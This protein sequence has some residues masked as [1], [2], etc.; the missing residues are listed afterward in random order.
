MLR[1]VLMAYDG[2]GVAAMACR[3]E[4]V[5]VAQTPSTRLAACGAPGAAMA[6]PWGGGCSWL[7]RHRRDGNAKAKKGRR[8]NTGEQSEKSRTPNRKLGRSADVRCAWAVGLI[9][10]DLRKSAS[11][12][13]VAVAVR[14]INGTPGKKAR[15]C[16]S[17]R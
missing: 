16:P 2:D 17:L 12:A 13:C 1:V 5:F 10:R 4:G 8:H 14:A 9:L 3:C 7:I 15:N 11:Q 6:C